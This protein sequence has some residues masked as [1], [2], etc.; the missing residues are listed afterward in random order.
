MNSMRSSITRN[1][2]PEQRPMAALLAADNPVEDESD[3]AAVMSGA[4]PVEFTS[5]TEDVGAALAAEWEAV[6]GCTLP[7]MVV[8]RPSGTEPPPNWVTSAG[9]GQHGSASDPEPASSRQRSGLGSVG[10]P[11]SKME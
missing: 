8:L 11:G 9:G 10:G 7:G 2:I 4:V 6:L 1:A 3:D 5:E